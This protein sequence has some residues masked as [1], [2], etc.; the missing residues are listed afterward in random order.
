MSQSDFDEKLDALFGEIDFEEGA[1][2]AR[3]ERFEMRLTVGEMN[4]LKAR[5][6]MYKTVPA[7]LIRHYCCGDPRKGIEPLLSA[8]DWAMAG[9]YVSYRQEANRLRSEVF[10]L[11]QEL[12]R[13]GNNVNQIA[14]KVNGTGDFTRNED[15]RMSQEFSHFKTELQ[16]LEKRCDRLLVSYEGLKPFTPQEV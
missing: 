6:K 14:R 5:A 4:G 7:K 16:A 1:G 9:D 10:R 3:T 15:M 2:E 13:V 8:N 12:N 11:R